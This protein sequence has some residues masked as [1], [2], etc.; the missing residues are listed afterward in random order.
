MLQRHKPV[1]SVQWILCIQYE[2]VRLRSRDI[3]QRI[4]GNH[5]EMRRLTVG[6]RPATDEPRQVRS[7]GA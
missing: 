1:K 5:S 2:L 7:T 4:L 6:I 3:L